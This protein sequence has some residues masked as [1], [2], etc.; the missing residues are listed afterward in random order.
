MNINSNNNIT[1]R[2]KKINHVEVRRVLPKLENVKATFVEFTSSKKDL[3]ALDDIN[4][5]W[6]NNSF[7]ENIKNEVY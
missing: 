1:F 5:Y 4:Y 2:A 7:I 6:Q 3:S